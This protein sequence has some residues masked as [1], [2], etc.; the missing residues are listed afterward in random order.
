M[1]RTPKTTPTRYGRLAFRAAGGALLVLVIAWG[2]H[3]L[4]GATVRG[5]VVHGTGHAAEAEVLDLARVSLDSALYAV[6][7]VVVADRVRRHPWV[8]EA[9]V[10]R[11]PTGT[12]SIRVHE[13]KPVLLA[14][15]QAGEPVYYVDAEGFRMPYAPGS[16]YPVPVLRGLAER[17][18]PVTPIRHAGVRALA[19]ALVDLDP[20]VDALL[21][22]FRA[23]PDGS[24]QL[25]TAPTPRGRT[26][27]VRLGSTD[28]RARLERLRAFWEQVVLVRPDARFAWI[29][30]R[31]DSQIVTSESS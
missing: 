5:L 10:S 25:D 17:Y 20:D 7:P 8:R 22:E 19:A 23:L 30:L 24:V 31:F 9:T 11:L 3:G 12:V 27:T 2:W 1:T 15:S 4:S 21:S 6:S 26:L 13:R 18:H 29:D 14:L 28:L 16:D